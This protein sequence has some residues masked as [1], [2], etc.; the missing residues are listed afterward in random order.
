MISNLKNKHHH[1]HKHDHKHNHEYKHQHQHQHDH[2]HKH[3]LNKNDHKY[4][5]E[6][7]YVWEYC[8]YCCARVSVHMC[9][10]GTH[11]QWTSSHSRLSCRFALYIEAR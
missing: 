8:V 4:E 11:L 10:Y 5:R 9:V 3:G 6:I 2:N 7:F 1:S